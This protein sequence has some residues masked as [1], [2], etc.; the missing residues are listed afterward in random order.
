MNPQR[1]PE[2]LNKFR[3]IVRAIRPFLKFSLSKMY[4]EELLLNTPDGNRPY[5]Y[6]EGGYTLFSP[7]NSVAKFFGRIFINILE[8]NA[9]FGVQDKYFKIFDKKKRFFK[10]CQIL[11]LILETLAL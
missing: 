1:C 7:Q 4:Q 2:R 11:R 6:T 8:T 3:N 5:M 9:K 10:F